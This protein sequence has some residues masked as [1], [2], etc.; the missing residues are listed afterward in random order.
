MYDLEYKKYQQGWWK[1]LQ[2]GAPIGFIICAIFN[3][4]VFLSI[5]GMDPLNAFYISMF[6]LIGVCL[7]CEK[8]SRES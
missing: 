4:E 8:R 5:T 3:G 1:G 2:C 7:Y 6:V